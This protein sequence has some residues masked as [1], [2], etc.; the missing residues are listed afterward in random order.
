MGA[1]NLNTIWILGW[2]ILY[3]R[4]VLYAVGR[5]A[6]SLASTHRMSVVPSPRLWQPPLSLD[7]GKR[8]LE[9]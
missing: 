2:I 3:G 8:F 6:A 4:G 7:I 5:L 1:L 9:G